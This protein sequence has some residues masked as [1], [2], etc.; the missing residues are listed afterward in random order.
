M[1]GT[2]SR[3]IL[4]H[5]EMR[6]K[7]M[8]VLFVFPELYITLYLYFLYSYSVD[9]GTLQIDNTTHYSKTMLGNIKAYC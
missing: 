4:L 9:G 2:S 3:A 5:H 7:D 1:A 8:D 6:W